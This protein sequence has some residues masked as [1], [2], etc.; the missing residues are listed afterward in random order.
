MKRW[1][2]GKIGKALWY[3][4]LKLIWKSKG[5][6]KGKYVGGTATGLFWNVSKGTGKVLTGHGTVVVDLETEETVC[7]FN[8]EN[9]R[10]PAWAIESFARRILPDIQK[11]YSHE[12]NQ[13]KH[14]K[15]KKNKTRINSKN[16]G[17]DG[18]IVLPSAV[19][20]S[21]IL[22]VLIYNYHMHRGLADAEFPRRRTHRC[23]VF[24]QVKGQLTGP[25]LHVP[26]DSA[27]L[28][29]HTM[30]HHYMPGFPAAEHRL[31]PCH[32]NHFLV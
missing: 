6:H 10:P 17:W 5:C 13:R 2:E 16:R 22:N 26:F 9:Y 3:C 21:P 31:F 19:I 18:I 20:V 32:G 29:S 14:E 15:W 11:F 23:P 27:P 24:Y 28:L 25:L 30:H 8:M 1:D 7:K 4:S 12:E